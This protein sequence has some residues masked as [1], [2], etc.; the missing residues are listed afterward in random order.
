MPQ[1]VFDVLS[2]RLDE[3]AARLPQELEDL[4][5][6][7]A[8]DIEGI[9]KAGMAG[10]HSGAVYGGHQAS[11]PGEMP[12]ID[13]SN[14]ASSIQVE[15]ERPEAYVVYTEA[16]Y[17]VPLEYGAAGGLAARPFMTPAAEEARAEMESGAQRLARRLG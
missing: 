5:E 12:A 3:I 13:T 11:A 8:R 15:K 14:L 6:A 2:N 1:I 4:L 16:D 9:V 10:P 17:A 7:T